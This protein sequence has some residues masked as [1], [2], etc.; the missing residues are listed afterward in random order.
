MWIGFPKTQARTYRA[1]SFEAGWIENQDINE[2]D[3]HR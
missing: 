1:R 3:K 2:E